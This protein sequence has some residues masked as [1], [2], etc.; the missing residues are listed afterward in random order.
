MG[1]VNAG[2]KIQSERKRTTS[3]TCTNDSD[4][5]NCVIQSAGTPGGHTSYDHNNILYRRIVQLV[6]HNTTIF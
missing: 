3:S 6:R 4:G 1:L 2:K 5:L